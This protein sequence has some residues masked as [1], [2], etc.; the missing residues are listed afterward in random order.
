MREIKQEEI[1]VEYIDHMGTDIRISNVAKVSFNKWDDEGDEINDKQVGLLNY[2]A[3]GLPSGERDDWEKRAKASTH[4][5]PFCHAVLSVRC[6]AP[7]FLARQLVK[8][9]IGLSWN[10]ESRRYI[11]DNI[12]LYMPEAVHKKPDSAKQ[13]ASKEAHDGLVVAKFDNTFCYTNAKELIQ[14]CSN[15]SVLTYYALLDAGVAPEEARMVLPLNSMTHW[16]WTG[17]LMAFLRVAKQRADG[18]AQTA[19]REFAH[20]LLA[21]LKEKFPESVKAFNLDI[22]GEVF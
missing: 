14:D 11:T 20:K 12:A 19:A 1:S 17:S 4:F 5:S 16:V 8:H 21:I 3:T 13:G 18:H 6:A 22:E 2:L 7:L 15:Q 9:Q 10:E